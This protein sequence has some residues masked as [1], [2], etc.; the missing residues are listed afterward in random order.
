MTSSLVIFGAS[1][2]VGSSILRLAS[3]PS[4]QSVTGVC[5]T[6]PPGSTLSFLKGNALEATSY[7]SLLTPTTSC[8]HSIGA[9]YNGMNGNSIVDANYTS[10]MTIARELAQRSTAASKPPCFVYI[11]A[12]NAPPGL[13]EYLET[14]RNAECD[15]AEIEGIRVVILRFALNDN[16]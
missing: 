16:F 8:I 7:S 1:G 4:F 13:S 2:F 12:A 11:S 5:R 9:L 14:K 15:L 6:P 10:A 3:S